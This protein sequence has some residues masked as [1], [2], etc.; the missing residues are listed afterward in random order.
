MYE[1]EET[2]SKLAKNIMNLRFFAFI[3]VLSKIISQIKAVIEAK[4]ICI[5]SYN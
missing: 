3:I 2:S 1:I 4:Q 5:T